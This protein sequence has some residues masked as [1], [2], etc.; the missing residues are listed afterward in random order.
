MI[1]QNEITQYKISKNRFSDHE[2]AEC[3]FCGNPME[4]AGAWFA[5]PSPECSYAISAD[6]RNV[7][8]A[9]IDEGHDTLR[10]AQIAA[11]YVPALDD[12][13]DPVEKSRFRVTDESSANWVLRK[14]ADL[15]TRR[16]AA[17]A[18]LDNELDA[19][20]RRFARVLKPIDNQIAFFDAAF[21]TEL[22]AWAKTSL[23]NRKERSVKLLHG[24]IGF[25][26]KPDALV[27]EDEADII[28]YAERTGLECVVRVKKE[29]A[30][31]A[32]KKLLQTDP[33]IAEALLPVAR[34]EPGGDEFYVKPEAL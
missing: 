4:E 32:L 23:E 5:C 34:I 17:Q 33:D 8:A 28:D 25:R 7:Y 27:I 30:K 15:Q 2:Q 6:V 3:P 31:T 11:M 22:A 29:V 18:M 13:V 9:L 21:R 12:D 24:S 14:L 1:A 26:K 20:Q 10:A 19:I 16:A